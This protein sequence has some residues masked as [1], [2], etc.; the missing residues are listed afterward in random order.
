MLCLCNYYIVIIS[1]LKTNAMNIENATLRRQGEDELGAYARLIIKTA[2]PRTT[3][4]RF[5]A[6]QNE[7]GT[8]TPAIIPDTERMMDSH[9]LKR[10]EELFKKE[11]ERLNP[12][13]ARSIEQNRQRAE[14]LE[15]IIAD[16]GKINEWFGKSAFLTRASAFDD[17]ENGVDVIMEF[18]F[19]TPSTESPDGVEYLALAIDA[20]TRKDIEG[21]TDK[22]TRNIHKI[23]TDRQKR[24]V[25][26]FESSR[27][28]SKKSLTGV[29]PL[30]V[31]ID[32][33]HTDDLV[34]MIAS[35]IKMKERA[36]QQNSQIIATRMA[37]V[38]DH[39]C[40]IAFIKEMLS[41]L[42]LYA[43]IIKKEKTATAEKDLRAITRV[44]QYLAQTLREKQPI[45]S[46]NNEIL[47]LDGVVYNIGTVC[48]SWLAKLQRSNER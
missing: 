3:I 4:D 9:L 28:G 34:A 2:S 13:E 36:P 33:H 21:I 40:Q 7:D 10:M 37:A 48:E 22:I 31:G 24:M 11:L 35:I 39:F 17:I 6:K 46:A 27:D 15:I 47:G 19:E 41:Q 25:K 20:S 26:Y 18:V 32:A 1:F 45:Q 14:A 44:R 23:A 16:Y 29:I 8:I 42:G 43:E 38:K 12:R 5:G 30:V